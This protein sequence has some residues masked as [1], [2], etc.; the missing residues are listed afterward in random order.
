MLG[1]RNSAAAGDPVLMLRLT[2]T[3]PRDTR[4]RRPGVTGAVTSSESE[5]AL[6]GPGVA[7]G[8]LP[9]A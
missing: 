8:P 9:V 6:A 5:R 3:A 2:V 1:G 7:F 4:P